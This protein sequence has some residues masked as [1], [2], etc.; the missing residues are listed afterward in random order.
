MDDTTSRNKASTSL[1]SIDDFCVPPKEPTTTRVSFR[2]NFDKKDKLKNIRVKNRQIRSRRPQAMHIDID[3]AV[4]QFVDEF[5]NK[6]EK[7]IDQWESEPPL[8][9]T[10]DGKK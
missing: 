10:A 9:S 6:M 4:E 3:A 7:R 2:F 8:K 1:D 5:I